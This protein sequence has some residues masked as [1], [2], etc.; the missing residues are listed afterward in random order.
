[1]LLDCWDLK[2]RAWEKGGTSKEARVE[3]GWLC[4]DWEDQER[5]WKVRITNDGCFPSHRVHLFWDH[6]IKRNRTVSTTYWACQRVSLFPITHVI[7]LKLKNNNSIGQE[8]LNSLSTPISTQVSFL[9]SNSIEER[10]PIGRN[11]L[12]NSYGFSSEFS[13]WVTECSYF[14]RAFR[15][16]FKQY[17]FLY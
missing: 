11:L 8:P 3:E 2:D 6:Q 10:W 9:N 13:L 5:G 7:P 1:M 12:L 15:K 4:E 14:L 17:L 16:A